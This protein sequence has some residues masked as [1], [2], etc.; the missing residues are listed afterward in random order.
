[1]KHAIAPVQ[2]PLRDRP[3]EGLPPADPLC[4]LLQEDCRQPATDH[5]FIRLVDPDIIGLVEVDSGSYRSSNACQAEQ[6]ANELG[7]HFVVE[8]KYS[9]S[10]F[11]HRVPIIRQQSNALLSRDQILD[12]SF[13]YFSQGVKRLIIK[14]NSNR[15]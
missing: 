11:V 2:H 15:S 1:M 14:P 7:Y 3:Q 12:S 5:H 13:H 10:S 4:R 6:I 8:T 9:G